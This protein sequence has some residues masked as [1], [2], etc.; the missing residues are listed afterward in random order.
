M[1]TTEKRVHTVINTTMP[2]QKYPWLGRAG[3]SIP[4]PLPPP[5]QEEG[6]LGSAALGGWR[7]TAGAASQG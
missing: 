6:E 2:V 7:M 3:A 4:L 1:A 5:G